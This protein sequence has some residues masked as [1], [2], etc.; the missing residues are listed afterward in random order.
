MKGYRVVFKSPGVVD[1]E[2]FLVDSPKSNELLVRTLYTLISPGTETAYLMALPNTPQ[3]F[4]QYPGYSNIGVVEKIGKDVTNFKEG[5]IVASASEHAS[6][7]K[8]L[9]KSTFKVPEELSLQEASFFRLGAIALQGVRKSKIELGESAAVLGLGLVG[10]LAAQLLKLSGALPV[11]AIDLVDNRLSIA[12]ALGADYVFNPS[13]VNVEEEIKKVVGEKGPD[14]V[15][16]ATGNPD[17]V[18]LAFKLA[19]TKGRVVLLGSTRGTS[20]VN[21]YEI[22]KKGLTVIGAHGSV[23]P[24]YES[25]KGYWTEE[26]DVKT[27][28]KLMNKGLLRCKELISKVIKFN[29]AP[30]AYKLLLER[31]DEVLGVL[32][33]WS[34]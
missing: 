25:Y 3:V 13:K 34:H 15:V 16:E 31:R 1:I 28:F 11:V 18:S 29:E 7:V 33:E 24:S 5:E 6:Y 9:A 30:K 19:S 4:P 20:T 32:L 23:R 21:F 17:A 22:H 2:S 8:P 10:Q 12:K 14:I 26:D 27:I